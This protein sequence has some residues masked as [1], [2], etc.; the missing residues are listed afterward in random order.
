M[1]IEK[2]KLNQLLRIGILLCCL[3]LEGALVWYNFFGRSGVQDGAALAFA[4]LALLFA[5]T[6]TGAIPVPA[7][8]KIP[9]FGVWP[10]LSDSVKAV[11]SFVAIFVWTPLAKQLVPDSLIGVIIILAPDALFALAAL[12]YL[13]NGLSRGN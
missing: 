6:L 9:F 11:T 1:S 7:S 5:L 4:S 13:S 2:P 3:A 8:I 12:V 10:K